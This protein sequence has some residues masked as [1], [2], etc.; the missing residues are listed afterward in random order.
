MQLPPV[1][2]FFS[3]LSTLARSQYHKEMDEKMQS[4][5]MFSFCHCLLPSF[6]FFK[7]RNLHGGFFQK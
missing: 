7:K 1:T 4:V 6:L 3:R 5:I 2:D